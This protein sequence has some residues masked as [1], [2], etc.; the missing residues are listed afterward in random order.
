MNITARPGFGFSK[1]R[2]FWLEDHQGK[3]YLD[4]LRVIKQ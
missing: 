2:G 1:G 3:R 4:M